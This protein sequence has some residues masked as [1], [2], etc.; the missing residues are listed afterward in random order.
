MEFL[1]ELFGGE[2]L[3]YEQL[4]EAAKSAKL[5]I[6]DVADGGYVRREKLDALTAARDG[7]AG[8]LAEATAQMERFE[9]MDVDG[10]RAAADEWKAKYE[11]ETAALKEQM[12]AAEYGFAVREATTG[13]QFTSD[14]ARKAFTADLTAQKLPLQEGKLLGLDD[15]VKN[16]RE[17]DPAA[18]MP[19]GG[20]PTLVLG[21]GNQSPLTD[22]TREQYRKMPYTERLKLKTER[23]ELYQSIQTE[24]E[25]KF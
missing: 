7:L 21:G 16:Y 24:T 22:V 19:A 20:V 6:V 18:F 25:R 14:S 4:A 1:K 2:A 5:E 11:A 17:S 15:F 12:A 13:M 3:T 9:G 10:I 8:Q 23:P